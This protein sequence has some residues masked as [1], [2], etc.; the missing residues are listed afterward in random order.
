MES[1]NLNKSL[2]DA[3]R[4][5]DISGRIIRYAVSES[6]SSSTE[7]SGGSSITTSGT[8]TTKAQGYEFRYPSAENDMRYRRARANLGP[9]FLNAWRMAEMC[10]HGNTTFK[11]ELD[12][13]D[14]QVKKLQ[15]A[16]LDTILTTSFD[17]V[18]T[19][20]FTVREIMSAPVNQ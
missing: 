16:Y 20:V 17:G 3:Y 2:D 13:I 6:E 8:N 19:G 14:R 11:N 1:I 10:K 15:V 7:T 18:V 9:E 5:A 4:R 12:A